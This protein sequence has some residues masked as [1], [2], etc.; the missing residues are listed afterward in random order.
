MIHAQKN[1][2]MLCE[3]C[4]CIHTRVTKEKHMQHN[5]DGTSNP[6]QDIT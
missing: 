1:T 4:P 6:A 5:D 3:A 2:T